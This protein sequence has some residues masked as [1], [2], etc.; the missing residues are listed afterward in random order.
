MS[1]TITYHGRT[2][3]AWEARTVQCGGTRTISGWIT[4]AWVSP[5]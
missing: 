1:E 4:S 5:A 2:F 3:Y